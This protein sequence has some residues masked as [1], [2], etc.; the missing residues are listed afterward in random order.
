LG[1]VERVAWVVGIPTCPSGAEVAESH[2]L[3]ILDE[4]HV[5]GPVHEIAE[6]RET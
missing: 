5:D 1:V 6:H 2:D 4:F 3:K